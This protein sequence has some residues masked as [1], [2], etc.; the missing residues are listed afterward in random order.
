MSYHIRFKPGDHRR[1]IFAAAWPE[2]EIPVSDPRPAP[3][4]LNG[5]GMRFCYMLNLAVTSAE[6]L[7][8]VAEG[9]L[10]HTDVYPDRTAVQNVVAEF[11]LR[12]FPIIAENTI[13]IA[14]STDAK[15]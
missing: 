10:R 2:G 9:I 7:E 6:Q 5:V 13:L 3:R 14:E 12:G 8:I 1:E 11:I 15:S 4:V